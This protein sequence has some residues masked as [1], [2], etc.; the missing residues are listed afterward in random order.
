[1]PI[2]PEAGGRA[3]SEEEEEQAGAKKVGKAAP[4]APVARKGP[5]RRR[6][7]LTVTRALQ[8]DDERVRS[9]YLGERREGRDG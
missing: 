8:A 5:D 2:E 7:K 6:G 4:K 9:V 1:M 3:V